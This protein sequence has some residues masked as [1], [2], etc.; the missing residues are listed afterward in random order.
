MVRRGRRRG[1]TLTLGIIKTIFC[2][3][4]NKSES[5]EIF[6]QKMHKKSEQPQQQQ[7]QT[8]R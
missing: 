6:M 4:Q 7:Q 8:R 1:A 2:V 3:T 5:V